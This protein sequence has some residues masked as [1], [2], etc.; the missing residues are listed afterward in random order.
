MKNA[1]HVILLFL[2][3]V[4]IGREDP[5]VNPFFRA[6]LPNMKKIFGP[7]IP[8]KKKSRASSERASFVPIKA[9]LG[10]KGLPQ[11]GT[12]QSALL[13][14]V[15]CS[16]FIGKHFGPHLYSTLKPV[17]EAKNIFVRLKSAGHKCCYV[18]AFPKQYF[19][20]ISR[21]SRD[22][23][24]SFAWRSSGEPLNGIE[25]LKNRAALSA[26]ITNEKWKELGYPELPPIGLDEAASRLIRIAGKCDF[27]LFEYFQTDHAG[28]S[29]SMEQSVKVLELI[30][31]FI[32][33]VY[34]LLDREKMLFL[35]TSDHGN[36]ED[37]SVRSHTRN[38]VPLWAFGAG[39]S[40]FVKDLKLLTD[41][42]PAIV[43]LLG[44]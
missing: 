21:N 12:G 19:D 13:T 10:V 15:N 33:E 9:T 6:N 32:G 42:T 24:I 35:A 7:A 17:V 4:G 44:S 23:A 27:V 43:R 8:S 3:G 34:E 14:G 1:E 30:D 18:N 26:D 11:S 2:D 20:Y 37:I 31:A 38:R 22:A 5:G 39:H 36:I 29:Q 25:E 16:K 40:K 28:H 41:I